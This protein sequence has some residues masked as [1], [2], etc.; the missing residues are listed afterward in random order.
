MVAFGSYLA[1]NVMDKSAA[2]AGIAIYNLSS[3]HEPLHLL[4]LAELG[5]LSTSRTPQ[6][7]W[8]Q[9]GCLIVNAGGTYKLLYHVSSNRTVR[10]TTNEV[11]MLAVNGAGLVAMGVKTTSP[12]VAP[13]VN[14]YHLVLPTLVLAFVHTF[15]LKDKPNAQHQV[16]F[17][18]PAI[19]FTYHLTSTAFVLVLDRVGLIALP[20]LNRSSVSTYALCSLFSE[21]CYCNNTSSSIASRDP[22]TLPSTLPSKIQST[23][24][25]RP[26]TT[27]ASSSTP[28]PELWRSQLERSQRMAIFAAAG[29][30]FI[31][32]LVG[33][34]VVWLARQRRTRHHRL[35]VTTDVLLDM[36]EGPLVELKNVCTQSKR[37]AVA[38]LEA[39]A[40]RCRS[41]RIA[42]YS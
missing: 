36:H 23:F 6:F 25:L 31:L 30:A 5:S 9:A 18:L 20:F 40:V 38:Q 16:P 13:E 1:I 35:Q 34:V 42:A 14:I 26:I 37:A 11:D 2:A 4:P 22:R 33:L 17:L 41:S 10:V 12:I 7:F 24:P 32:V 27:N 15:E 28:R 8:L 3:F 39:H 29:S 19:D 21:A